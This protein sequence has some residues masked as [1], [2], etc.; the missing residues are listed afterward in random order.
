MIIIPQQ[1]NGSTSKYM[2]TLTMYLT[3]SIYSKQ[4]EIIFFNDH[5]HELTCVRQIHV[6]VPTQK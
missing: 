6:H 2:T 4:W 3:L 5:L 1:N